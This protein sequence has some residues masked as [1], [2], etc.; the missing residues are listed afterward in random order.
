[1]YVMNSSVKLKSFVFSVIIKNEAVSLQ[2]KKSESEKVKQF[3]IYYE[4]NH[5]ML[6]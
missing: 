5:K 2:V 4:Q 1:M 6:C 3:F